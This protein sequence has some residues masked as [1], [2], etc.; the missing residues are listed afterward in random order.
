MEKKKKN[1]AS[2]NTTTVLFAEKNWCW[3]NFRVEE[4]FL[5]SISKYW[6]S[7]K[8]FSDEGMHEAL[9]PQ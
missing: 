9:H 5:P 2:S 6:Y 8:K 3:C 7:L 4:S 1:W